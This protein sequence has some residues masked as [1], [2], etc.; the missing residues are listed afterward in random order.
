MK[1]PIAILQK[2][3]KTLMSSLV[4]G[5]VSLILVVGVIYAWTEP[6]QAP[7]GGNVSA[8]LNVGSIGQSKS[9]GL[10][11][12][13][14]GAAIGLIVDK[15][16]VG[17][18]TTSPGAKLQINPP[19][20]IEGLRI[21]SASNWSPLNIRNSANNTDIF[22]VNQSGD[23]SVLKGISY[24]WPTSQGA[25]NTVLTNN[26]SGGLTWS[27]AGVS[28]QWTT[29]GNNIYY[30]PA[31]GEVE[32]IGPAEN[33]LQA[34][35][36][37][38]ASKIAADIN[39]GYKFTPNTNG[40]ITRLGLRCDSG[41]RT[42]RL[43]DMSGTVLASANVTAAGV[44]AWAYTDITPVSVTAN[45][46]YVVAVRSG[47]GNYCY[48]NP[49]TTPVTSGNIIINDSRYFSS[50]DAMPTTVSSG[51]SGSM[52]GQAD[53]TFKTKTVTGTGGY[54]GIGTASPG[55]KL[56]VAGDVKI[57]SWA[58]QNLA[59]NGY[60]WVGSLLFQ[61]GTYTSTSD[62]NQTFS[63]PTPFPTASLSFS[64]NGIAQASASKTKSTF[65]INRF[66]DISGSVEFYMIAI[67]Y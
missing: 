47:S 8:P 32:V 66:N 2:I 26:G 40:I 39:A 67:G 55:A 14:G 1:T 51:S 20:G 19:T 65:T 49:V 48:N 56:E 22:R 29:S 18:G 27:A 9:G 57:A 42:V 37:G 23:I 46:S 59:A 24:I 28:S 31:G 4:I 21:V 60:A 16:N 5:V 52:L 44:S 15:G 35:G 3:K 12:N 6:G 43:Y 45:T 41:T 54:V 13:T 10:I 17:I 36:L 62:D 38:A 25:A 50:S 34:L 30:N 58:G 64:T 63:F 53:V 61:W 7:P 11:L 33:P